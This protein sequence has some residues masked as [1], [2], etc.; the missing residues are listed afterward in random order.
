MSLL[1]PDPNSLAGWA[2]ERARDAHDDACIRRNELAQQAL[3]MLM[4]A[5]GNPL[6]TQQLDEASREVIV[7]WMEA[8]AYA[9]G[10]FSKRWQTFQA[11]KSTLDA[12]VHDPVT[13]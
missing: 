2:W 6:I 5:S 3:D 13:A 11:Y 10:A 7:Q 1:N 4:Q 8:C 9:A 12:A